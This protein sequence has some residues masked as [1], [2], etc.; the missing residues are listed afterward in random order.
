MGRFQLDAV[1]P[2]YRDSL[3]TQGYCEQGVRSPSFGLGADV[4][5]PLDRS[6]RAALHDLGIGV[7]LFF[8]LGITRGKFS[9]PSMRLLPKFGILP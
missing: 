5:R 6:N 9:Y 2:G 7:F 4:N 3:R 1:R 8:R